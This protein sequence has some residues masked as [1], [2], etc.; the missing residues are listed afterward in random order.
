MNEDW[1][2]EAQW[3][4]FHQSKIS[5]DYES[6]DWEKHYKETTQDE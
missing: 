2:S 6:I 4:V 3:K 5:E 1:R